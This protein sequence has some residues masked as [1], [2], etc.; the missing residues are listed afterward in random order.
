MTRPVLEVAR[1]DVDFDGRSAVR[2]VG[3]SLVRGEVLG[4]VGES[5]AGKSATALAVLGLLP[6]NAVVRGSVRLDGQELIGACERELTR[7]RGR[8]VSMVFQDPM[9]SLDPRM[10]VGDIIAG[11]LRTQGAARATVARRV[12]ELLTQA[13]LEPGHAERFPHEFSGGQRLAVP[14]GP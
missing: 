8:R 11:P 5:G 9:A 6:D 10:P 14:P 7:I 4:L 12:P 1:L 13:G 3:L 2:D